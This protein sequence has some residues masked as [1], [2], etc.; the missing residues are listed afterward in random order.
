[1][2]GKTSVYMMVLLV[3]ASLIGISS[4]HQY[5]E[6]QA[7]PPPAATPKPQQAQ[8]AEPVVAR[9]QVL[10]ATMFASKTCA[11][12]VKLTSGEP[13]ELGLPPGTTISL[14]GPSESSCILFGLSKIGKTEIT[15]DAQKISEQQ[16]G[17]YRATRVSL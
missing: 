13:N 1:M 4:I 10:F 17:F 12:I 9:G 5:I 3:A 15:F 2:L 7:P 6:G 14:M 11:A 8:K 16:E